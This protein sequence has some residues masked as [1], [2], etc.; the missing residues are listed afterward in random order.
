MVTRKSCCVCQKAGDEVTYH[1]F[2]ANP[3]LKKIWVSRVPLKNWQWKSSSRLCSNHF[4]PSDYKDESSDSNKRREKPCIKKKLLK[5]AALPSVWPSTTIHT[6]KKVPTQRPT[7]HAGAE[8]RAMSDAEKFNKVDAIQSF[9]CLKDGKINVPDGVRVIIADSHIAFMKME[10]RM[11]ETP[12]IDYC[13]LVYPCL[14]YEMYWKNQKITVSEINVSQPHIP[15][16]TSYSF[17]TG[18]LYGLEGKQDKRSNDDIICAIVDELEKVATSNEKKLGFLC[19]Q[20]KLLEK[21][22]TR[23]R[24][25]PDTLA[26]ACMWDNVS[27]ALY[28]LIQSSDVLTLPV[29]KYVRRLSSAI[30]VDFDVSESTKAYLQARKEKLKRKDLNVNIILDEVFLRKLLQYLNGRFFGKENGKVT[31]TL[32]NVMVKSVAGSYR[33]VVAMSPIDE[34]SAEK[35]HTVWKNVVKEVTRLGFNVVS[36]TA[37]GHRSNMKLFKTLLCGGELKPYIMNPFK[38]EQRIHLLFDFTHLMKCIYNNFRETECFVCPHFESDESDENAAGGSKSNIYPNFAHIRQLEHLERGKPIKIAHKLTEKVLKPL[39]LEK[40]NVMLANDLFHECTINGLEYYAKNGFGSFAHTAQF[41]RIIRN[42]WDTFNVKSPWKGVHK[43][44]QFME[45]VSEENLSRVS[46]YLTDF[47]DWVEEW[48]QEYPDFGLS[49]P[50]FQA[51]IHTVKAVKELCVYLL[52]NDNDIEYLLLGFL[53]QDFLEGRFGWYRQLSGGNYYCS[54]LQ[55]LQAEKTIRLRNLVTAGYNLKDIA[56]IF[57]VVDTKQSELMKQRSSL[58]AERLHS[59]TFT[60]RIRDDIPIT[61]YVAGY[62][63]G[64]LLKK[65]ACKSCLNLLSDNDEQLQIEIEDVGVKDDLAE[66]KAFLEAINRGGLVK[67]SELLF[68]VCTHANDLY[69]HIRGDDKLLSELLACQNAQGFFVEVF[70]CQLESFDETKV[71]V[72][73]SCEK[74]HKF[75]HYIRRAAATMFNLFAKNLTAECNSEIYKDRKRSKSIAEEKK[76]DKSRMKQKKMK[77]E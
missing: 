75:I 24:Y 38:K 11:N 63:A 3:S 74:D 56:K 40:T 2:P 49:S 76:R 26:V 68:I 39:A 16:L 46:K 65:T 54:V 61:Y 22:P 1:R 12:R 44:N 59:F 36:T 35:I 69:Q 64:Q 66:G 50:T 31:K 33:D 10:L 20:L 17:L 52:E 62:L 60:E 53:Q 25:S 45:Q 47:T 5:A 29:D 57:D 58:F 14:S 43:R 23:R 8:Q 28:R 6:M 19:E 34:I 73:L 37:D 71:M 27:P 72:N 7:S 9:E 77:S 21:K 18:V 32:L 42:W 41:L 30:T 55:F 4:L 51:L 67:P 70:L 48:K 15:K 13:L